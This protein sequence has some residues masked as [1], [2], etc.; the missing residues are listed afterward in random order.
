MSN[1]P[2]RTLRIQSGRVARTALLVL[3]LGLAAQVQPVAA[4]TGLPAPGPV[5]T[6]TTI[7]ASARLVADLAAHSDPAIRFSRLAP[8]EQ[9]A[10]I[11]FLS[12]ASTRTT[13]LP[14]RSGAFRG[15][16]AGHSAA[17][18]PGA[19][20]WTW[21]WERDAYNAFGFKLWAYFQEID[22]CDDGYT[23]I[24]APQL[25]NYGSTYFPFWSWVHAGDHAWGGAGQSMFRS[26]YQAN[27]SLCLTPN[28]GCIQNTYPWLDMTA[29]ANGTGAGS[30]G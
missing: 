9:G 6:A 30:V 16:S 15:E 25:L 2:W 22:W 3:G 10:V 20:C 27:F 24:H 29:R 26:W 1:T 28:V 7:A 12:V 14:S 17:T 18:A 4:T 19:G 5:S 11:R 23:M 8:A 13:E 21:K